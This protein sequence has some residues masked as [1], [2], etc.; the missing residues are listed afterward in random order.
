MKTSD[1]LK[2]KGKT[3]EI[4]EIKRKQELAYDKYALEYQKIIS[5]FHD[6]FHPYTVEHWRN[7]CIGKE[8][9]SL[10]CGDGYLEEELASVSKKMVGIDISKKQIELAR[11]KNANKK[12][13]SFLVA[14][15]ENLDFPDSSFDV[16]LSYGLLHHLPNPEKAIKKSLKFLKKGGHFF[17]FE[18]VKA[19][20]RGELDFWNIAFPP[21]KYLPLQFC[22]SILVKLFKVFFPEK[23]KSGYLK[24]HPGSPGRRHV[25]FY[26]KV[27]EELKVPGEVKILVFPIIPLYIAEK[28]SFIYKNLIKIS[29][30]L[31]K[32]PKFKGKGSISV[33]HFQK[34]KIR[35]NKR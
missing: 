26:Y 17:A 10:G 25:D 27:F 20:I 23:K 3:E 13:V 15:A 24:N 21:L 18:P 16:I 14:D 22:R 4:V 19:K 30:F 31:D 8:V 33:I 32:N 6:V 12:N 29:L 35:E 9:L 28:S 2:D 1:K 34:K 5:F 7:F 11:K